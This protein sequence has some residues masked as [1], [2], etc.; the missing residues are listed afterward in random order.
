MMPQDEKKPLMPASELLVAPGPHIWSGLSISKVMYIVVGALLLPVAASVY[1]FGIRSLFVIITSVVFSLITEWLSRKLRNKPFIMDGSAVVTGIL[2]A[3]VLPPGISLWMIAVGAVFAI[4]IVKEAFGGLGQNVFNP[5]LAARAFMSASFA[6]PMTTWLIPRTVDGITSATPLAKGFVFPSSLAARLALYK[7]MFI[8]N[9][10]GS[11]GETSVVAILVGGLILIALQI[12][13]W[14]IPVTYLGT[15]IVLSF[16]FGEDPLFQL[17]VGGLMLGAF[18]M[19]TDYV[20]SP[21]THRGRIIF[22]L[23]CGLVTM[24]IRLWGGLPEGVC[25]SILF[26]NAMTPII[27]RYVKVRPLGLKKAVRNAA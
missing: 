21:L 5:A 13:D 9:R 24:V 6:K 12:I 2:L 27:D 22:G 23:G 11:L 3:L 18:F 25:Y 17:M 19:A 7:D 1:F 15:V 14:R 10:V 8:G 20:T 4:A 16:A 26:M